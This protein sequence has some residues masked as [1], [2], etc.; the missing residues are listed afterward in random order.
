MQFP[1]SPVLCLGRDKQKLNFCFFPI[2]IPLAKP[3]PLV[4]LP[5]LAEQG[6]SIPLPSSISSV[7]T[8]N[9]PLMHKGRDSFHF[10][11][12]SFFFSLHLE[13]VSSHLKKSLGSWVGDRKCCVSG[14]WETLGCFLR[15]A[16]W[17]VWAFL[18]FLAVELHWSSLK[19]PTSLSWF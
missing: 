16:G 8:N 11:Y 13:T 3:C 17:P 18:Y 2:W 15:R 14:S 4:E 19:W 7:K 10:L 5:G 12:S 6:F 9:F 1:T